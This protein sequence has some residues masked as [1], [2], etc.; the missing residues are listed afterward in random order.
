M[1]TDIERA[2]EILRTGGLVAFP[3]ETVVRPRRRC[4]ESFSGSAS[5]CRQAPS[6]LTP[7]DRAP[8]GRILARCVGARR[9]RSCHP[10]RPTLLARPAHI[11]SSSRAARSGRSDWRTGHRG[12][13]R[14][15]ASR[16]ARAARV[17]RPRHCCT[18]GQPLRRRQSNASGSTYAP[19]LVRMW[20]SFSMVDR[21]R[22]ESNRQSWTCR[23]LA[24]RCCAPGG[25]LRQRSKPCLACRST[26]R[27]RI[28]RAHP[29]RSRRTTRRRPRLKSS[30]S[31]SWCHARAARDTRP[32]TR[33]QSVRR[34]HPSG[35]ISAGVSRSR[36]IC[37]RAVRNASRARWRRADVILVERSPDGFEWSGVRDRLQRASHRPR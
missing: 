34:R 3:T 31:A 36:R 29:G 12:T 33:L 26:W 5:V 8:R 25:S 13:T 23:R 6:V 15:C 19:T 24:P 20:T 37:A 21:V 18:V 22:S 7:A 28:G 14:T 17:L 32:G 11:D 2:A 1:T 4:V 10:A 27:M 30:T 9:L 16:G 35:G